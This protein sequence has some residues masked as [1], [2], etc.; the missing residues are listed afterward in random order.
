MHHHSDE[1]EH[2]EHDEHS[3]HSEHH[4]D[5][6]K[7]FLAGILLG[8]LAG[9]GATLLLTPQS[10][11]KT[12]AKI[13]RASMDMRDQTVAGVED[14]MA[15]A[16]ATGR[17]ISADVHQQVDDLQQ[18]GQAMV[19]EQKARVASMVEAWKEP[20]NGSGL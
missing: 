19:D 14:V 2:D 5:K 9:A 16:R 11:K 7:G 15:Q 18:R 4:G 20:A 8:S 10:G 13:Q 1:H 12:R 3:E 6:A 17:Q